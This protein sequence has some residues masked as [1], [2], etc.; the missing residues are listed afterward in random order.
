MSQGHIFISHSSKDDG[1]VKQLREALESHNLSVWADSRELSGGDKL[2]TEIESAI[3]QAR[4]FVA[5]ISPQTVNSPWVRKEIQKALEVEQ[6]RRDEGYKVIP[7]LLPGIE[8]SALGLWF[9]EETV[10][11][12]VE[13]KT[14]GLSE[15]LPALLA[16]LGEQLPN[17]RQPIIE[18]APQA[19]E[20]LI[21]KLENLKVETTDGQRRAK[22]DAKLIYEP[23]DQTARAVESKRYRFTA[24]L[25]AI[26]AE[27]LR[28]YLEE[29][30][31]WP[32]GIFKERAERIEAQLP[33]WGEGLYQ[34]AL[35][36]PAAQA[37][38][39]AWQQAGDGGE[40]RFS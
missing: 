19:V 20:E 17:D 11:V 1:F 12:R 16:A 26:E 15:V 22:A 38:L 2:E 6:R 29:Y 14:G 13:V 18:V 32:A 35:A 21:L 33:V 5:V 28:W 39:H 25:G 23:A 30:F 34:A 37:A 27:E 8:P 40:R 10:G 9:D 24:P 7:L 31:I 3:E 4:H 36:S